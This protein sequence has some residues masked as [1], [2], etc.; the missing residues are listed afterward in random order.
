MKLILCLLLTGC[1][2]GSVVDPE[3]LKEPPSEPQKPSVIQE[4]PKDPTP[5]PENCKLIRTV[6]GGNCILEE[7]KCADGSYR[8]DGRC[9]PPDWEFPHK[10]DP[11]PPFN[12]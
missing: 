4:G 1:A 9:Y 12:K 10:N 3:T 2:A 5:I 8:L 11:Y 6:R 7:Y